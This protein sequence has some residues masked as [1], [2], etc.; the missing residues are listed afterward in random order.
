MNEEGLKPHQTGTRHSA[1]SV[2][3]PITTTKLALS[4][5]L[6]RWEKKGDREE[7]RKYLF[8]TKVESAGGTKHGTYF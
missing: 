4:R 6:E 2:H 8:H 5:E 1:S 7:R 3:H